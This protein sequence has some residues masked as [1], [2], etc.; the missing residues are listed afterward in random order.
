MKPL[1]DMDIL[2]YE[3]GACGQYE[4]EEGNIVAK[5]FDGVA[6]AVDQ[7]IKEICAL[8]WA[9]EEPLCFLSMDARTK[10]RD[11]RK[12]ERKVKR[13]EKRL[14]GNPLD[15]SANAEVKVLK[16]QQ[17]YKPNFRENIAKKKVYKGN[18]AASVK[19]LHYDNITEYILAAYDCV[20]AE[21]LE[22]DD[23]LSIY[24]RK[25]MA[26]CKDPTTIICSRDKDLAQCNGMY[27]SWE[28]GR[29]KQ[30]GPV[31]VSGLGSLRPIYRG[32]NAKGEPKLAE[33]KGVGVSYF[34]AQM[35]MGDPTDNIPGLPGCGP[36]K[37]YPSL[38]DCNSEQELFTAVKELY[39][40]KFGD[41][42]AEEMLEQGR[43]LFMVQ[44]L[45]E[46]GKPIMWQL[47]EYLLE[48]V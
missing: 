30:F 23:L 32:K 27:F 7:K 42:W 46:D 29:Q 37:A 5:S 40:L 39:V 33:V 38:K 18:R 11:A 4:D 15:A 20:M 36:T 16:E 26:E 28:C 12:I 41:G 2:R 48:D 9:T 31:L 24:Q 21:G 34:A 22:A 45:D 10:K 35:L 17:V 13:L 3:I 6:A 47:P 1:I 14:E 8:V 25:A 44:E 19:P 43:L